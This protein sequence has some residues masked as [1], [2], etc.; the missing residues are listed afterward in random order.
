MTN[1][2]LIEVTQVASDAI[3]AAKKAVA[4]RGEEVVPGI[5]MAPSVPQDGDRP[6][7]ASGVAEAG[8]VRW[9]AFWGY[10]WTY[11]VWLAS[12][13]CVRI[14][15]PGTVAEAE[16]VAEVRR[17]RTRLDLLGNELAEAR[18]VIEQQRGQLKIMDVEHNSL[19]TVIRRNQA[20]VEAEMA[21]AT[22]RAAAET[23]AIAQG[24]A[25]VQG[26]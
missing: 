20:R 12:L 5:V 4:E 10:C 2:A 26:E 11:I 18:T 6:G 15:R 21:V 14:V 23:M 9:R 8:W 25:E 17:L 7:E 13:G 1:S 3:E 16:L 19:M 24:L 22:R